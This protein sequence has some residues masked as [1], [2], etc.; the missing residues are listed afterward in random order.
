[1][2]IGSLS[3]SLCY[4]HP[5]RSLSSLPWGTR[6]EQRNSQDFTLVKKKKP[7]FPSHCGFRCLPGHSLLFENSPS[8]LEKCTQPAPSLRP[9][10]D[11]WRHILSSEN[12]DW[13]SD[14][15]S[16]WRQEIQSVRNLQNEVGDGINTYITHWEFNVNQVL[17][18]EFP[19]YW[20]THHNLTTPRWFNLTREICL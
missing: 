6:C 8:H 15:F 7:P 4:P 3:S 5:R 10:T 19:M 20:L 12:L 14:G 17:F 16:C 1:M 11:T 13:D 2:N 18:E 9:Y